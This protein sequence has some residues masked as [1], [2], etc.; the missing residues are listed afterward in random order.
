MGVVGFWLSIRGVIPH[1]IPVGIGGDLDQVTR[2]G[3]RIS[4]HPRHL[5]HGVAA[6]KCHIDLFLRMFVNL[7]QDQPR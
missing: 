4:E 2:E 1:K 3:H 7:F 5:F 6:V